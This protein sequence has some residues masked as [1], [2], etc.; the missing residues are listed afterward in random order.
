MKKKG[1]LIFYILLILTIL[2][3]TFLV[4]H[5]ASLG[6]N[7]DVSIQDKK[8]EVK[9]SS[10]SEEGKGLGIYY[11]E[12]KAFEKLGYKPVSDVF[13]DEIQKIKG[14][15]ITSTLRNHAYYLA[16]LK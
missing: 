4:C 16:G 9:L 14:L 2:V 6:Y 8:I 15:F 10:T 13:T 12:L 7:I 11:S 1:V 3:V 5:V